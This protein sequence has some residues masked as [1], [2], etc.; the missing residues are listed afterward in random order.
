MRARAAR[1]VAAVF[2]LALSACGNLSA[3]PAIEVPTARPTMTSPGSRAL[4]WYERLRRAGPGELAQQ[5]KELTDGAGGAES[6]FKLA[7]LALHPQT[8]NLPRARN[9]LEDLADA[10]GAE[11]DALR[12]L[13]RL[14]LDQLAERQR[15]EQNGQRLTQQLE[16]QT[17]QLRDALQ[18]NAELQGKLDALAEIERSLT[19]PA[20][21]ANERSQP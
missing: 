14:L 20:P 17:Q 2:A 6:R 4:A 7:L 1:L 19:P 8:T 9:L 5:R 3:P 11:A 21:P 12:P 10:P 18:L 15:Q 16:R 13:V